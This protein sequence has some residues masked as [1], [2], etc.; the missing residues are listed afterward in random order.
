ML[1]GDDA[2]TLPLMA[3][4]GRGIISVASNE[5]PAEMVQMVEAAERGDFAAARHWHEK[6]LPIM[7]INFVES[8]PGP[9]EVR[10]GR[11]GPVRRGVPAA[12]G[13]AAAGVAGKDPGGAE[14]ARPADRRRGARVSLAETIAQLFGAGRAGGQG[15]RARGVL[16]TAE[17][18][19]GRRGARGR[20]GSGVAVRLARQ[21]LGEAGHSAR[22]PVRR[23][24]GRVRRSRPLAVLRQGHDAAEEARRRRRRPHRARADRRFA[25]A[26]LSIARSSACRRCT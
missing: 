23:H 17:A 9:G 26:R 20:A 19:V 25:K 3:I 14:G 22:L 5:V 2:L 13:A 11:D 7:Q 24:R 1:S 15:R 21:H 8:S 12:D 16:R 18:A 4:G 10:D 6:L